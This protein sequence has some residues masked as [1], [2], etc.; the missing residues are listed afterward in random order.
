MKQI[1]I[2]KI[3]I[4]LAVLQLFVSSVSA[5]ILTINYFNPEDDSLINS[6]TTNESVNITLPGTFLDIELETLDGNF[7]LFIE[8]LN[9]SEYDEVNLSARDI[10]LSSL[11]STLSNGAY[12]VIDAYAFKIKTDLNKTYKIMFNKSGAI[13][14]FIVKAQFNFTTNETNTTLANYSFT[15]YYDSEY[16]WINISDFSGFILTEDHCN[17]NVKDYDEEDVDC[18]GSCEACPTGGGGGRAAGA[19]APGAVAGVFIT[20]P[21]EVSKL[22]YVFSIVDP[23]SPI[24][25]PIDNPNIPITN[26]YIAVYEPAS[27]VEINIQAMERKPSIVP[28]APG[29]VYSYIDITALNLDNRNIYSGRFEFRVSQDWVRQ[30]SIDK[31]SII[32]YRYEGNWEELPTVFKKATGGYYYYETSVGKLSVYAISGEEAIPEVIPVVEEKPVVIPEEEKPEEIIPE[33]EPEKKFS[34]LLPFIILGIMMVLIL[35]A[36]I[37]V[38][39]HKHEVSRIKHREQLGLRPETLEK[40]EEIETTIKYGGPVV[41][42]I[43]AFPLKP[44]ESKEKPVITLKVV[45]GKVG[46]L[47]KYVDKAISKGFTKEE[48]SEVLLKKG[49]TKEIIEEVLKN[50]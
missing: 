6:T 24:L 35:I 23:D 39:R 44:K 34:P 33:V 36:A 43:K 25:L 4:I 41:E 42:E 29:I 11:P 49:W 32:L 26:I 22:S 18:G 20:G 38:Y 2:I 3:A 16:A 12:A 27:M 40:G 17:N 14:P 28:D 48:I 9:V 10:N 50:K 5:E 47:R 30:N 7:K 8:E 1:N 37:E 19:A 21:A 15:T 46:Q 13:E 45:E 31:E